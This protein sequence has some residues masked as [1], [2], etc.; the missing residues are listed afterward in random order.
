MRDH[1]SRAGS[2]LCAAQSGSCWHIDSLTVLVD[3]PMRQQ[4]A[5]HEL[6]TQ[7]ATTLS[8]PPGRHQT[9]AFLLLLMLK[10]RG[11]VQGASHGGHRLFDAAIPRGSS[12]APLLNIFI[13]I[14]RKG[15]FLQLRPRQPNP[16]IKWSTSSLL[17]SHSHGT[18]QRQHSH[19]VESTC[20][21]SITVRARCT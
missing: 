14:E 10:L 15:S 4:C 9:A 19:V 21:W 8:R 5:V 11:F 13:L 17:R 7:A 18:A 1:V 12:S 2:Q 6:A 20:R 16:W 3:E